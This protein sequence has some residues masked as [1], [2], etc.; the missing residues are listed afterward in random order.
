MANGRPPEE[1]ITAT[2]R[3]VSISALQRGDQ[4]LDGADRAEIC[5][6]N[7]R[8]RY[9]K[10]EPGLDRKHKLDHV[11]RSEADIAEVIMRRYRTI[12]RSFGEHS[13]NH[14]DDSAL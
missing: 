3:L 10:I 9:A 6:S 14:F 2:A 4:G 8:L 1:T 5:R 12:D 11:E 7:V 13:T